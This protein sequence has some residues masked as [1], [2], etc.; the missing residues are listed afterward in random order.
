MIIQDPKT[1][2]KGA[3]DLSGE[4]VIE[5]EHYSISPFHEGLSF[6]H[7]KDRVGCYYIN[8][9]GEKV[10]EKV[11]GRSILFGRSFDLS[12]ETMVILSDDGSEEQYALI[13]R[14]GKVILYKSKDGEDS[15]II[16]EKDPKSYS[17]RFELK[18]SEIFQ[19]KWIIDPDVPVT[20]YADNERYGIF[21]NATKT[22]VTELIYNAVTP[23]AEGHAL[24][25]DKDQRMLLIDEK[26]NELL[27]I[28]KK[29]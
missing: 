15:K 3:I 10:I 27:D 21:D 28:S 6:V 18:P 20:F 12:G 8:T 26:G 14:Q 16:N 4:L 17:V 11:D 7:T 22:F 2:L 5:P 1:E 19:N 13:D 23:F 25:V 9:K 24:V 29:I